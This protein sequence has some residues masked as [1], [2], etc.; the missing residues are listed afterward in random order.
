[1][2]KDNRGAFY[3]RWGAGKEKKAEWWWNQ[4]RVKATKE[5]ISVNSL[6]TKMLDLWLKKGIVKTK[7][8]DK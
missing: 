7:G 4:V 8:G 2:A 5:G 1:M 3:Y 6:I